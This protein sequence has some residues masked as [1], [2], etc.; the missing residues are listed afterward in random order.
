MKKYIVFDCETTNSLDDPIFFDIGWAVI[1]EEGAVYETASYVN[2]DV[3]LDDELMSVAYYAEKIPQYWAEIKA[4]TRKLAKTKTIKRALAEA[5]KKWNVD[6]LIAHNA[7]FDYRATNCTQR[8]LTSSKQRYF[9][10]YG[11][12]LWDT[13]KMAR[14]AFNDEAYDTFCYENGYLTKR[15]CKRYTAEILYRFLTGN[16]DFVEEH[17]GLADCLIEK[18]IFVECMRRG[19]TNGALW[20]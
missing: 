17:T 2:A 16:N 19:I 7:R 9:L 8:Y 20:G 1:D 12:Q 15:G 11:I 10:P 13:L 3:F 14:K 18:E 6:T 5:C 4:G